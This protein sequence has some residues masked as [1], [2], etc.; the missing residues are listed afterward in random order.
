MKKISKWK[1]GG[2]MSYWENSCS[3]DSR[4]LHQYQSRTTQRSDNYAIFEPADI[5]PNNSTNQWWVGSKAWKCVVH[6]R[7]STWWF[8][9]PLILQEKRFWNVVKL[10]LACLKTIFQNGTRRNI[11]R[12]KSNQVDEK[13]NRHFSQDETLNF[14]GL[15]T[16][17]RP[18]STWEQPSVKK[19]LSVILETTFN[20][21][22]QNS[23]TGPPELAVISNV[24]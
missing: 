14:L 2:S 23:L 20:L 17:G 16:V 18:T 7:R 1:R 13:S 22:I 24:L 6:K 4:T 21:N 10:L 3:K 11:S 8:F 9:V 19:N 15:G 12:G 5:L